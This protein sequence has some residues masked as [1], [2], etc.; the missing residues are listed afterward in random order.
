MGFDVLTGGRNEVLNLFFDHDVYN[1]WRPEMGPGAWSL[2]E[3]LTSPW[4]LVP[5]SPVLGAIGEHSPLPQGVPP[6]YTEGMRSM[7]WQDLS[8]PAMKRKFLH[9]YLEWRHR[10]SS[11]DPADQKVWVFGWHEHTNNLFTDDGTYGN[12]RN[13]RD[14]VQ[15]FVGWLNEH[16]INR[17]T[18]DGRPIAEYASV[19]EVAQEFR[20]WEAA[21]PDQS[22]FSY[23]VRERDWNLYPYKLKGLT[24]ELMYAHYER[25][26]TAFRDQ[27]V[28]VHELLKTG[29]R[30]WRYEGG[31]ITSAGPTRSIY[32]LWSEAGERTVDFSNV[33][34]GEIRCVDG[35][36]GAEVL[37]PAEALR[38][39]E[40]PIVCMKN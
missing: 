35:E 23:P 1:P 33:L 38:V 20:T 31:R 32:L 11:R 4:L 24:R 15:E 29:G 30:N 37:Q 9:L 40:V 6:E 10:Q 36:T 39:A 16:F 14:E 34:A 19:E 18:A 8:I 21:Y 7:I 25:E 26:I 13:L 3:D 27:G 17:R 12:I 22:S 2:A 28:Y 5:Q